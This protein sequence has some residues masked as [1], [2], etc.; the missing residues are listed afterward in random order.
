MALPDVLRTLLTTTGPSGYETAPA[1]AWRDA[2]SGFADVSVD[3]MGS[4]I[5]RV[6]GTGDGPTLAIVG[7]IDEIGL[8]V[9]HVDDKGY[10]WFSGFGWDAQ[11]LIGQRVSV[12]TAN[13]AVPGVIGRKPVHLLS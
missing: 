4:S 13:G 9:T 10:L 2:A 1:A 6:K 5:A 11:I 8:I 12:S 3:V 7:H